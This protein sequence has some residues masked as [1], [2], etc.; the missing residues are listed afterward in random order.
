MS[1]ARLIRFTFA[2]LLALICSSALHA[3]N[4]SCPWLTQ[5]SAATALGGPVTA[6]VQ[7]SGSGEGTCAFTR[8]QGTNDSLKISVQRASQE[9]CPDDSAKLKGIGNEAVLCKIRRSPN[10]LIQ[11][12]VSRVR[13]LH[14]TVRFSL[15]G[16][17]R[18]GDLNRAEEAVKQIAEQV[19]GNLF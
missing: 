11:I 8:Q 15:R 17:S 1:G 10:E 19:A 13:E 3:A 5:G 14:F 18:A 9:S 12:V 2:L 7:I 6:T 4:S 16:E